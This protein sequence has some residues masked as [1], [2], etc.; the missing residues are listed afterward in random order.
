MVAGRP[1]IGFEDYIWMVQCLMNILLSIQKLLIQLFDRLW[2]I[3][4]VLVLLLVPPL[5]VT[6]SMI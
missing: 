5:V 3:T 1:I 2:P 6:I 4:K